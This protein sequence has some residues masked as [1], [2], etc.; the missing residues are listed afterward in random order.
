MEFI[1]SSKMKCSKFE[2]FY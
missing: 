2:F 1:L